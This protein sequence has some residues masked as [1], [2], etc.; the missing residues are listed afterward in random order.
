MRTFWEQEEYQLTEDDEEFLQWQHDCWKNEGKCAMCGSDTETTVSD[1][2]R[3]VGN[4]RKTCYLR[5]R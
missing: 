4:L 1:P 5:L 3:W 2:P